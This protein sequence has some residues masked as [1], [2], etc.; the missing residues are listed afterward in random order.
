MGPWSNIGLGTILKRKK[1]RLVKYL[2]IVKKKI[3]NLKF[4]KIKF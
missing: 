4:Y 2:I 1:M 3:E